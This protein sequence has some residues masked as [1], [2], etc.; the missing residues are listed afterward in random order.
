MKDE[1][2]FT[3]LAKENQDSEYTWINLEHNSVIVGK[4]RAIPQKDT[5]VICSITVFPEYQRHGYAKAIMDVFKKQYKVIT[6][7]RVRFT[8]I[9]FWME[10][11]FSSDGNGC[12]TFRREKG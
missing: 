12:Y 5:L 11:G 4:V 3:I 10:M 2:T 6:A 7:D 9:E 8:A 1:L